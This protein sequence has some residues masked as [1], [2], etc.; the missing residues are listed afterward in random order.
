MGKTLK[1]HYE[2][3]RN[4]V[5]PYWASAPDSAASTSTSMLLCQ[6]VDRLPLVGKRDP[7]AGRAFGAPGTGHGGTEHCPLR[8]QRTEE[9][10]DRLGLCQRKAPPDSRKGGLMRQLLDL[11]RE[12]V[13]LKRELTSVGEKVQA[14]HRLLV[15]IPA[16]RKEYTMPRIIQLAPD[17]GG[18]YI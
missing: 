15:G 13:A 7:A 5:R 14:V 8:G 9:T 16:T 10:S 3:R 2:L 12:N 6:P 1:T 17:G 11:A 4:S 18:R